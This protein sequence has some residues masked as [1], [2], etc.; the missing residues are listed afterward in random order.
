[1]SYNN[2]A[3]I[4]VTNNTGGRV[5]ITLS[6]KYSD[7]SVQSITWDNVESGATTS[8]ALSVGFNTG[9][10]RTGHDYWFCGVHVQDGANAGCYTTEGS[11]DDPKKQCTMESEDN[12]TNAVFSLSTT[13]FTMNL[14]SGPCSTSM[15]SID[16]AT[17]HARK[18]NK[19]KK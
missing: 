1:M 9:F 11:A 4:T 17:A 19:S 10:L 14:L 13:D 5:T 3:N 2:S 8:P 12:G 16:C 15:N 6:H 7:D 18:S